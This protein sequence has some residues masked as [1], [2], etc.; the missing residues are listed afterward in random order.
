MSSFEAVLLWILQL[1]ILFKNKIIP[2]IFLILSMSMMVL[3]KL[4]TW[5][6]YKIGC[7]VYVMSD[8]IHRLMMKGVASCDLK[9][10][11]KKRLNRIGVKNFYWKYNLIINFN[12]DRY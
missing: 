9:V 3:S 2:Y 6:L 7:P 8:I 5:I 12:I 4:N 10:C 11:L 1:G